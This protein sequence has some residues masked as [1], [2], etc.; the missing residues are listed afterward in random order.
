M[1]RASRRRRSLVTLPPSAI[2]SRGTAKSA[3]KASEFSEQ[4]TKGGSIEPPF[5]SYDRLQLMSARL[6]PARPKKRP[7]TALFHP[8]R[9]A[10]PPVPLSSTACRRY[11]VLL[12]PADPAKTHR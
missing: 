5:V 3:R 4:R 1:A 2:K 6:L 12:T 8:D 9:T 11:T 7:Q 10:S